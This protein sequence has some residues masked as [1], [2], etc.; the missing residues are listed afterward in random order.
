M[1]VNAL[2]GIV[3]ALLEPLLAVLPDANLALPFTQEFG[4]RL[5]LLD[6]VVPILGPLRLIST[7]LGFFGALFAVR[8]ALWAWKLLPGKA[9]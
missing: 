4:I 8:A 6:R 7:L 5:G 9:S 3:C 1:I 2:I